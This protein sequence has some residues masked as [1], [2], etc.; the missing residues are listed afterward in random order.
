M[1]G[2]QFPA[3]CT[4]PLAQTLRAVEALA[5]DVG[6]ARRYAEFRRAMVYGETIEYAAC[7]ETLQELTQ[8]LC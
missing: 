5:T 6:Y 3:Y 2:N 8:Q 1:F 7:M 4:N